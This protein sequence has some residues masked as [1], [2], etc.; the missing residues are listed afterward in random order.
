[1]QHRR[2]GLNPW[3]GK[4]PWR[5]ERP[6]TPVFWPAQS[7]GL[8]IQSIE[9]WRV[10]RDSNFHFHPKQ[11][12]SSP[13]TQLM[14][15]PDTSWGAKARSHLHLFSSLRA[16]GQLVTKVCFSR[17]STYNSITPASFSNWLLQTFSSG[18]VSCQLQS[19][20][21]AQSFIRTTFTGARCSSLWP[22]KM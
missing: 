3:V 15:S 13:L 2:P 9:S 17:T 20:L 5:K 21:F 1:M 22:L 19:F 16:H 7:Q 14:A 10:G 4:I 18:A 11:Y 12:P 8:T 6:P